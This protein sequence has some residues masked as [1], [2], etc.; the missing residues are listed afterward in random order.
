MIYVLV[1]P[2]SFSI[3]ITSIWE[4]GAYLCVSRTFVCLFCACMFLSFFFSYWCRGLA[5]V[6]DCGIT[7]IFL[8]TFWPQCEKL[9]IERQIRRETEND[10]YYN[11]AVF[12][13]KNLLDV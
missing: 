7:W 6:C 12:Y 8:L 9:K 1:S 4:E 2:V 10:V 5:A 13:S 11:M 3:L